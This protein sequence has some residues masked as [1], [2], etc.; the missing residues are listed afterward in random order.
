MEMGYVERRGGSLVDTTG[1]LL[2][3][4]PS[5]HCSLDDAPRSGP[6]GAG[7]T[8]RGLRGAWSCLDRGNR[9]GDWL[10]HS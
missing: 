1:L 2:R 6:P 7:R 5:I 4:W 8:S 3:E 9:S 10:I